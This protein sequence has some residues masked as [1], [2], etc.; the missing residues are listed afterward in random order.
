MVKTLWARRITELREKGLSL[1]EIGQETGLA[2]ST[3]SDL[4]QGR[5]DSPRGEAAL[6]LHD[7]H[8]RKCGRLEKRAASG[9]PA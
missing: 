1:A 8:R 2:T 6:K 9:S 5:H 7:L 3:V 4:E